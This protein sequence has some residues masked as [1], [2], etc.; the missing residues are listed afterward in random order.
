MA[1]KIFQVGILLTPHYDH[2]RYYTNS[3]LTEWDNPFSD[4]LTTIILLELRESIIGRKNAVG[5]IL[6]GDKIRYVYLSDM[7]ILK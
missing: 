1:D 7:D 6:L 2:T 5:K 4:F 3:G